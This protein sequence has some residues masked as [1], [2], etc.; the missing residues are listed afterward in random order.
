MSGNHA[1]AGEGAAQ[2][3]GEFSLTQRLRVPLAAEIGR[4]GNRARGVPSAIDPDDHTNRWIQRARGH[5]CANF[6]PRIKVDGS[7]QAHA[8]DRVHL[9]PWHGESDC[10][11][12]HPSRCPVRDTAWHGVAGEFLGE[13]K[14]EG[15]QRLIMR[16]ALR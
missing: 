3:I 6:C 10:R 7:R 14:G 8:V 9:D 5:T 16:R 13:T 4:A 1:S 2:T 15:R 12:K 11:S